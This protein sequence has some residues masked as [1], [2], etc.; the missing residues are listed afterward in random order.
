MPVPPGLTRTYMS[1]SSFAGRLLALAGTLTLAL[2]GTAAAD[3][4]VQV[5]NTPAGSYIKKSNLAASDLS[6]EG[7]LQTRV[8]LPT[9]YDSKKCWPVLYL[10]HGTG[11][12]PESPA[13]TEWFDRGFVQQANIPA[14]V[15]VPGGGEMW[16]TDQ[17]TAGKHE[18]QWEQWVW[19]VVK[20]KVDKQYNICAGRNQHSIA[21]LSM[22]GLGA[23]YLASQRPSYF[24][25]AASFSGVISLH[26]PIWTVYGT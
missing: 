21:G 2:A 11:A 13:P 9:G 6:P 12:Y 10:L 25:T 1:R 22:G 14:I 5:L 16:W 19:N 18:A 23:L 17:F 24:G 3:P 8:M 15:V 20:P 26:Q 4:A 7:Q